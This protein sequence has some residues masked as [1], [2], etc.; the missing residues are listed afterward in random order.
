MPAPTVLRPTGRDDE[1]EVYQWTDDRWQ[2]I[3]DSGLTLRLD[4]ALE[5][6][7]DDPDDLFFESD[8]HAWEDGDEPAA[9]TEARRELA[10]MFLFCGVVGGAVGG[11]FSSPL[12]GGAV[13]VATSVLFAVVRELFKGNWKTA[14]AVQ[15]F[16]GLPG[17][18]LAGTS[19]VLGASLHQGAGSG[20]WGAACGIVV[21]AMSAII[22][23]TGRPA[24]WGLGLAAG[25]L[26][27]LQVVESSG[28]SNQV[29]RRRHQR[30]GQTSLHS[31]GR[32]HHMT[33][34]QDVVDPVVLHPQVNLSA[35]R[36]S[37]NEDATFGNLEDPAWHGT[38]LPPHRR[39]E[40]SNIHQNAIT[41]VDVHL[42]LLPLQTSDLRRSLATAQR[43][44]AAFLE[45]LV[46]HPRVH[47]QT[48]LTMC[49][50]TARNV[51][52]GPLIS[53]ILSP[54]ECTARRSNWLEFRF[55]PDPG[56]DVCEGC[57]DWE[58]IPGLGVASLLLKVGA[59]H[60][61]NERDPLR[62]ECV[63]PHRLFARCVCTPGTVPGQN[64]RGRRAVVPQRLGGQYHG[65]LPFTLGWI[66]RSVPRRAG[67]RCDSQDLQSAKRQHNCNWTH[68]SAMGTTSRF[69]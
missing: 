27:G 11:G 29:L 64:G 6:I 50:A 26:L 56:G 35:G 25:T 55:G 4:E 32:A 41:L 9:F 12:T 44:W 49:A 48:G 17:A 60:E 19:A 65:I 34:F 24:A 62:R 63:S 18:V 22:M 46:P 38:R 3:T 30:R 21:G 66:T 23:L 1:V 53:A 20:F 7:T 40:R 5:F 15:V 28:L 45:S 69:R 54:R 36:L 37:R 16:C 57:I 10:A 59:F 13:G 39:D 31:I 61:E 67:N 33:P 2:R 68:R 43:T 42:T 58:T 52:G 47:S 8:P 14:I 51:I